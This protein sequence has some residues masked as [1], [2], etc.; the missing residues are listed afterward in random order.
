[1]VDATGGTGRAAT[2]DVLQELL[3]DAPGETVTLAWLIGALRRRSFGLVML[4]MGVVALVPGGS[5]I[6]GVLLL[7][8]AA[9]MMLG[10]ESPSLPHFI[11]ERRISTARLAN[12]TR[13]AAAALKW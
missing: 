7:Y 1:M 13:R 12:V 9:Q 11:A 2:S 10:R 3:R 4:L 5:T 8:P 6:I